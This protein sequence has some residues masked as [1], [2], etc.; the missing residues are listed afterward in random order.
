[1]RDTEAEPEDGAK[2]IGIAAQGL[3]HQ[4]QLLRKTVVV[5]EGEEELGQSPS[6]A[7]K[8]KPKAKSKAKK[9][10]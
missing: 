9:K 6:D 5:I 1:M 7:G 3:S 2:I 10:Q 8:P 4:G